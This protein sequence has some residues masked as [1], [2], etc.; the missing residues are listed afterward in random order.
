[1][2]KWSRGISMDVVQ[3]FLKN[4]C[5]YS[6]R[7][8]YNIVQEPLSYK[9]SCVHYRRW[10]RKS[11]DG[12]AR[13]LFLSHGRETDTRRESS[14]GYKQFIHQWFIPKGILAHLIQRASRKQEDTSVRSS[15]FDELFWIKHFCTR[16]Y[17]SR[18]IT[19]RFERNVRFL[20]ES[21]N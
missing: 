2:C 5:C 16:A 14:T 9:Y 11:E 6:E 21:I 10:S 1:M 4:A 3:T 18:S 8:L 7:S 12:C 13:S 20:T 15:L 17:F 19:L